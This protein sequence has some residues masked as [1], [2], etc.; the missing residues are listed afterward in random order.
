MLATIKECSS[1]KAALDPSAPAVE[2]DFYKAGPKGCSRYFKKWYFNTHPTGAVDGV[3]ESICKAA[4]G[5]AEEIAR[6][7]LD[8]LITRYSID[9]GVHIFSLSVKS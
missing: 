9:T 4:A 8:T 2:P 6:K 7:E 5:K 3:T 1:A